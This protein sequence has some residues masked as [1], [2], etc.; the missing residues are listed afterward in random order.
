MEDL[1]LAIALM[2]LLSVSTFAV[3]SRMLRRASAMLLDTLA[4][5]TLVLIGAYI[6]LVWGQL[7]IVNWIPL[8]SVII[9]ANWF[10]IL[11]AMLAAI[12]WTRMAASSRLRR[13]PAQIALIAMAVGSVLYVIPQAPPECGDEWIPPEPPVPFR[14]CRQTTPLTCSAAS[15]ATMLECLGIP[16]TEA[17]MSKL[18]LTRGGTTWLGM[19]HGLSIKLMGSEFHAR[20]FE[21]EVDDL[22]K[23]TA[24]RPVLLCCQLDEQTA[25]KMPDYKEAAGWIPGVLHSVV[26]FGQIDGV[27]LIGDPSQYRLERWS[28]RDVIN[29]WTGTGLTI[30]VANDPVLKGNRVNKD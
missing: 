12:W 6:Y 22:V 18:C 4:V 3:T 10:P 7:W 23:L 5:V 21:G 25:E 9:L 14:I 19:Y 15:V 29:L 8:P 27:F 24:T 28:R 20:F 1:R 30:T 26:C 17:E 2:A 11:L 16:A 13:L